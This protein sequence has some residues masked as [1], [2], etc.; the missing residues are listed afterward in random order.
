[1]KKS[2]IVFFSLVTSLTI[3]TS[4]GCDKES[5]EQSIDSFIP[6]NWVL[7]DSANGDLNKDNSDD[8]AIVV[9]NTDKK[10][11]ILNDGDSINKNPY[12]L[13]ILFKDKKS[14]S[15][16]FITK[17][18]KFIP[19]DIAPPA[20]SP[21][22]NI[23]IVKNNLKIE[24]TSGVVGLYH[25]TDNYL[26]RYQDND[27]ALIGTEISSTVNADDKTID[28]SINFLT[29]KYSI[30]ENGKTEWKTF[31]LKSL[32]TLTT[33]SEVDTWNFIGLDL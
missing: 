26:F 5:K 30:T 2:T 29:K 20:F 21:F 8:V 4:C 9:R 27:F 11:I 25:S 22:N 7:I 3:L 10:N 12:S 1:M 19:C 17:N 15:Y 31:E 14:N 24:F 32:K 28:Y 6:E 18:D 13:I 33:L 16:K 23:S